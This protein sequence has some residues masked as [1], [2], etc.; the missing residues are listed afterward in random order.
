MLSFLRKRLLLIAASAMT[1]CVAMHP[2]FAQ[3]TGV[4][5][6]AYTRVMLKGWAS[7]ILLLR[8]DKNLN[9]S[10]L[11]QPVGYGPYDGWIPI[12]MTV[13]AN[14]Y[15]Y[16]LWRRTGGQ[17]TLWKL[18]GGFNLISHAEYGPYYAWLAESLGI[19]TDGASYLRLIWRNVDGNVDIWCVDPNLNYCGDK[20]QGSYQGYPQ[21]AGTVSS[22]ET[23]AESP[24]ARTSQTTAAAAMIT[25]A[26][27][28]VPMPHEMVRPGSH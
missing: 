14:N 22:A 3:T 25:D 17:I 6:D 1:A 5:S 12:A 4:G 27:A 16:V 2:S 20:Q 23:P 7:S 8:V 13:A 10:A 18:D 21:E 24:A 26:P 19:D 11:L 28:P 15:S 9:Q